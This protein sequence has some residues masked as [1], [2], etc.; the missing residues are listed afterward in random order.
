MTLGSG[1]GSEQNKFCY[2]ILEVVIFIRKRSWVRGMAVLR[3]KVCGRAV[4]DGQ[5]WSCGQLTFEQRPK[6]GIRVSCMSLGRSTYQVMDGDN[7][8]VL[9]DQQGGLCGQYWWKLGCQLEARAQGPAGPGEDCI[10]LLVR[11]K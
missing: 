6:E 1:H 11:R 10:L 7:V 9:R 3:T 2:L 5:K 4:R 8:L